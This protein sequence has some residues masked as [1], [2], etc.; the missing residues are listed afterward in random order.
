MTSLFF[1]PLW[2]Q[3]HDQYEAF[4][5]LEHLY[6]TALKSVKNSEIY[7]E[8]CNSLANVCLMLAEY[9]ESIESKEVRRSET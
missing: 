8:T 3:F 9:T 1:T 7:A 2:I 5:F 4:K 6:K